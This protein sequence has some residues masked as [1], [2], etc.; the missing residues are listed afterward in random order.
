MGK[1]G[2][3]SILFVVVLLAVAVIAEAQQPAKIP[4]VGYL[5]N[6]S[7]SALS[8]RTEAFRQGLRELG[9]IEGKNIVL[10]WRDAEG[11]LD[12]LNELAV[13]LVRL[14]VDVIV[15]AGGQATRSAKEATMTIPIVMTQ[16]RDPVSEGF[17]ASLARPGGNITGLSRV[18]PELSGKQ[19][20]LL[21]EIIPR[22]SRV[23]VLVSLTQSSRTRTQTLKEIE[24]AARA[25]GVKLQYLDV[26][27]LKD[28]EAAFRAARKGQA[29]AVLWLVSG[30]IGGTQ[31]SRIAELAVQS[32]LPAIYEQAEYVEAGGLMSYGVSF[33]DLDRRAATYV[34]KILKGAKPADLPVEQPKKFE[35]IVNLKAAKQIGLTIPPNVLARSDRVIR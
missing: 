12:R 9:Q 23:A 28:I 27:S 10:E 34:D 31:R 35:F 29:D 17:I 32:R 16:D 33:T 11:K 1:A 8:A 5:T 25:F 26:Q 7:L 14:R 20:E 4:R 21:K 6:E 13:E 19:L 2:D 30:P 15:T 3:L 22:L 24:V 18:A